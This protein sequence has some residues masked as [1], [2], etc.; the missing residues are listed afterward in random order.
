[1]VSAAVMACF[2]SGCAASHKTVVKPGQAPAAVQTATREQLIENYNRQAEA[3]QTLNAGVAMKLTSGSAYSGVIEQYHEVNGFLLAARPASIRVIGQAPVIGK[4]IFDMVSDGKT[5]EIS[6]PSKHKFVTGPVNVRR[7]SSKPIENLRPQHLTDALLWAAL[8]TQS[9]VLFEESSEANVRYYVLTVLR[10][11]TGVNRAAES[12]TDFEIAE[13]IWFD[14]ADLHVARVEGFAAGGVVGSDVRYSDWQPAGERSYPRQIDIAR[15][16]EDYQLAIHINKLTL[17]APL[18][19]DAFT[20]KQ[21]AGE[22][23]V[24]V[25]EDG[26]EKTEPATKEP[27]Q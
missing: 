17:N 13:K 22:D 21:L 4:N 18:A 11:P 8:P 1:M 15:P 24:R 26:S 2:A 14:R 23:L 27:Q 19:A 16:G 7:P 12:A 25:G 9:T 3:I 10:A 5:F 20:L 6:I